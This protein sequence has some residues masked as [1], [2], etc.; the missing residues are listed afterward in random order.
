M[1]SGFLVNSVRQFGGKH[2]FGNLAD[3]FAITLS[4]QAQNNG[5][6]IIG[7]R[8]TVEVQWL[9]DGM[10]ELYFKVNIFFRSSFVFHLK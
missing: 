3:S 1:S 8:M 6:F 2:G 9:L 10:P 5:R 7:S 4:G